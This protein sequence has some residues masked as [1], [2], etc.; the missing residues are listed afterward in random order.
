MTPTD[1]KITPLFLGAEQAD[2]AF[3][4]RLGQ[5]AEARTALVD[6]V[7]ALRHESQVEP[8]VLVETFAAMTCALAEE[9]YGVDDARVWVRDLLP[10]VLE[11][12]AGAQT[13]RL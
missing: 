3:Q 4:A 6:A 9:L 8:D 12:V 1:D 7:Q 5:M 10:E 2:A 13:S 11:A